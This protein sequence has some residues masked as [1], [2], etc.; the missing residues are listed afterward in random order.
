MKR[1]EK[2]NFIECCFATDR[3]GMRLAL[4]KNDQKFGFPSIKFTFVN[5]DILFSVQI[6][7]I[8]QQILQE[9]NESITL[10]KVILFSFLFA[11]LRWSSLRLHGTK[12]RYNEIENR[13]FS[14]IHFETAFLPAFD[15]VSI[16]KASK[17]IFHIWAKMRHQSLAF[18]FDSFDGLHCNFI[19]DVLLRRMI[20]TLIL[21]SV[22]SSHRHLQSTWI[23]SMSCCFFLF[24]FFL[25]AEQEKALN[26]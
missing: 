8:E 13:F 18:N 17:S 25:C 6:V 4:S 24:N 20:D 7:W 9:F 14:L 10:K 22:R 19:C 16:W 2:K 11:D 3:S 23:E 15:T 12:T 21:F 1:K 5:T 26:S